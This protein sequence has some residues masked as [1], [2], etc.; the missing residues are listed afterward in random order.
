MKTKLK[1]VLQA[2][3][4]CVG[5]GVFFTPITAMAGGPEDVTPPELNAVLDGET[6][7]IEVSDDYTGVEAVYIGGKRVNCRMKDNFDVRFDGF[8]TPEDK[9]VA[10]Y[11]VDYAG[12]RSKEVEVE[13]P[14]Y[15]NK[16][17]ETAKTKEDTDTETKMDTKADTEMDIPGGQ[18]TLIED[19]SEAEDGSGREFYT[20]STPAGNVFYLVI[21]KEKDSEN[22]YF[23]NAVTESDLIALAEA[24]AEKNGKY[25][26]TRTEI[27]AVEEACTCTDK[28]E[29]GKVDTDC[30]VCRNNL[31]LCRGKEVQPEEKE[32]EKAETSTEQ[33]GNGVTVILVL[34]VALVI[35][36]AGYY[37]KIYKPKHELDDAEDLDEVLQDYGGQEVDE[38]AEDD[39]QETAGDP[40]NYGEQETDGGSQGYGE[41]KDTMTGDTGEY[42]AETENGAAPYTGKSGQDGG[43]SPDTSEWDDYPDYD[44][45]QE[46]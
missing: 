23:L 7:H 36:G 2:L 3:L 38:D 5:M 4:L 43:E 42:G 17:E 40:E 25:S 31:T 33:K 29:A 44:M 16:A 8:A 13:N 21:D 24:E 27:P 41:Q 35:G 10:V 37:L 6:L 46:E 9:T 19:I 26:D 28:C 18:A 22:V 15:A 45:G 39:G 1:A 30:P 32:A 34:L 11:A 14:L 20:F 12:N